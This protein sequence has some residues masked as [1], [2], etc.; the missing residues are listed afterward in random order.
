MCILMVEDEALIVEIMTEALEDAGYDVLT[1]ST[2]PQAIAKNESWC[3]RFSALISDFH[4]PGG[5]TGLEVAAAMRHRRPGLPVVMATG[6]PD[7]LEGHWQDSRGYL[8]LQK[9]YTPTDML[10]ALRPLVPPVRG[11]KDLSSRSM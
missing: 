8:L 1:A 3:D 6:R 4:L 2:G 7:A 9:P 5:M 11:Q 10:C